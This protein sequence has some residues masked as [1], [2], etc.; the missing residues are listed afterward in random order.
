VGD[1]IRVKV[2]KVDAGLKKITVGLRQTE[3][4]PFHLFADNY[5]K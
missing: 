4:N 3:P 5:N 2:L 1:S